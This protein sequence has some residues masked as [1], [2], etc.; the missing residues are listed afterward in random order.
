[1]VLRV[2]VNII[3]KLSAAHKECFIIIVAQFQ[4]IL[5]TITLECTMGLFSFGTDEPSSSDEFSGF[6]GDE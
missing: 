4:R 2:L 3:L 1:M 6:S 5:R